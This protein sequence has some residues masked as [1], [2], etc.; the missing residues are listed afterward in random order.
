M[1]AKERQAFVVGAYAE[2]TLA[3]EPKTGIV[4]YFRP[5]ITY[6]CILIEL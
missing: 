4:Q 1:V 5:V 3:A 2:V 6:N